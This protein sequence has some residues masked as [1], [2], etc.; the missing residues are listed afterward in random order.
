MG[1]FKAKQPTHVKE[2]VWPPDMIIIYQAK[3]YISFHSSFE[4]LQHALCPHRS[5]DPA[6]LAPG[7]S[8]LLSPFRHS[9]RFPFVPCRHCA[10][11]SLYPFAP[12]ALPRFFA[13]TGTLTPARLA[14][15]TLFKGNEHQP[16]SGQVSLFH[17][18][19][20]SMHSVT[21]HPTH[22][23]TAFSLSTQRGGLP[24]SPPTGIPSASGLDFTM[25]E[26]ARRYVRPNRVRY[27]TDCIFTFGCSPPR[28]AATQLPLVTGSGHLPEGT[29]TPKARLLRGALIPAGFL[30]RNP[31]FKVFGPRQE[32]CRGDRI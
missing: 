30:G 6:P 28:L 27:P 3:P 2:T 16:C 18:T 19:C 20:L 17:M 10:S 22:P 4:G 29:F 5:F 26:L 21:N 24:E 23:V 32:A 31:G 14:L 12:Q 11:I 1:S 9:R 15:R 13:T 8:H 7:L 25:N